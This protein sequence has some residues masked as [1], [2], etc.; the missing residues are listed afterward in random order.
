MGAEVLEAA[1][2]RCLREI[3]QDPVAPA[4]CGTAAKQVLALWRG[5]GRQDIDWFADRVVLVARAAQMSRHKLFA[6]DVRAEGWPD[7]IDRTNDVATICV[8]R[9]WDERL[10][11]AERWARDS[12]RLSEPRPGVEVAM[13][14]RRRWVERGSTTWQ[15]LD[16]PRTM[17]A[18][19]LDILRHSI[20]TKLSGPARAA[21]LAEAERLAELE[22]TSGSVTAVVAAALRWLGEW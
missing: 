18:E 1:V 19:Y 2:V 14:L 20:E 16:P 6:R 22:P 12:G 10:A 21:A 3:R 15:P 9:R 17:F 13:A 5:L 7:G 8:Q 11:V 4:R